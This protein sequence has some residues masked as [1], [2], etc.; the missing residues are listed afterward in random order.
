MLGGDGE[1]A[2]RA[3]EAEKTL[4][5]SVGLSPDDVWTRAE[6]VMRRQGHLTTEGPTTLEDLR[7]GIKA[8]QHVIGEPRTGILDRRT[9]DHIL[10]DD[11]EIAPP[12]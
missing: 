7:E 8:Y 10:E 1:S 2:L 12:R 6:R 11:I 3:T 4:I 5:S 9:L